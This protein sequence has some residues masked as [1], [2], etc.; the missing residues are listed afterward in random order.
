M[1]RRTVLAG[2]IACG[3]GLAGCNPPPPAAV[4]AQTAPPVP[5]ASPP[6]LPGWEPVALPKV[7]K[8][9]GR[10]VLP[11]T[12]TYFWQ[13]EREVLF[14]RPAAHGIF[15][16]S[17]LAVGSGNERP[18]PELNQR[19]RGRLRRNKMRIV[20]PGQ[21]EGE[22]HF[23]QPAIYLSSDGRWLLWHGGLQWTVQ[24]LET[25]EELRWRQPSPC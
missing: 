22:L 21:P 25:G 19:L 5:A 12:G 17:S 1:R 3:I 4:P 13:S 14:V 23:R 6:L 24:S 7:A 9:I 16:L 2:I 15:Q 8:R 11:T 10:G 18:L 20:S